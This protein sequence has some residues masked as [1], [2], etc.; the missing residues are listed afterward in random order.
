MAIGCYFGMKDLEAHVSDR[1]KV[2]SFGFQ[3]VRDDSGE[4]V[5]VADDP[6][7]GHGEARVQ[8]C[9][10]FEMIVATVFEN[11][12]AIEYKKT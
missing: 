7:I 3:Y 5:R 9:E 8:A 2:P 4:F 6:N 10:W 12:F 11:P 1:S